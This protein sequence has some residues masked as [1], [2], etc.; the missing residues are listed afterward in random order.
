[1]STNDRTRHGWQTADSLVS[2]AVFSSL[3]DV[4]ALLKA[5]AETY[6]TREDQLGFALTVA[7][8][9]VTAHTSTLKRLEAGGTDVAALLMNSAVARGKSLDEADKRDWPSN[10]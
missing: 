8:A 3:D 2:T 4:P 5:E 1:M 7:I 6:D 10:E 9:A